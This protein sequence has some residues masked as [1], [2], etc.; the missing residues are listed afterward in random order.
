MVNPYSAYKKQSVQTMTPVEVVIKMYS[1]IERQLA[2]GVCAIDELKDYAKANDALIKAQELIGALRG[3]LD[4]SVPISKNLED[5]YIFFQNETMKA[6]IKKNTSEIQKIIPMIA[7][8][9][10][11]FTQISQMTKEEIE[12]QAKAN[13]KK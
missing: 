9:R 3:V 12:A 2:I 4:M 1:E 5:L 11:A 6:N 13:S 7:D 10:D 8:L